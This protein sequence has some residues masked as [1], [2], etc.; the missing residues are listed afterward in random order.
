MQLAS[1]ARSKSKTY[2][3]ISPLMEDGTMVGI[4]LP[5]LPFDLDIACP[6]NTSWQASTVTEI[7]TSARSIITDVAEE[8]DEVYN[9]LTRRYWETLYL[10]ESLASVEHLCA[11]LLR[12]RRD[13]PA[14]TSNDLDSATD[15]AKQ[16]QEE[17]VSGT[18]RKRNQADRS[19]EEIP[20]PLLRLLLTIP[21]LE[22]KHRQGVAVVLSR[23]TSPY[24]GLAYPAKSNVPTEK[25]GD[26]MSTL[27][28]ADS[29]ANEYFSPLEMR[30]L[31]N[32]IKMRNASGRAEDDMFAL[33]RHLDAEVEQSYQESR[34]GMPQQGLQPGS[35][36]GKALEQGHSA[37]TAETASSEVSAK[38]LDIRTRKEEL[39]ASVMAASIKALREQ[40]ERREVLL[41]VILLL[42]INHLYET[43]TPL[44]REGE[45]AVGDE[46]AVQ[47]EDIESEYRIRK[48][49]KK[50]KK[51][52][53]S[54]VSTIHELAASAPRAVRRKRRR[55]ISAGVDNEDQETPNPAVM[56][57]LFADRLAL[58]QA[59]GVGNLGDVGP[60]PDHGAMEAG[61]SLDFD[62]ASDTDEQYVSGGPTRAGSRVKRATLPSARSMEEWDWIQRFCVCIV[63][64]YFLEI[65]HKFCE[66]FH[67]KVFGEALASTESGGEQEQP[68]DNYDTMSVHT[69]NTDTSAGGRERS[70]SRA[71]SVTS[72][73][74]RANSRL[75]SSNSLEPS[76]ALHGDQHEHSS[77][78][79]HFSR[80]PSVNS[81]NS[82][83]PL[84][85]TKSTANSSQLF[86]NRQVG[87]TRTNSSYLSATAN[88]SVNIVMG[89]R[90]TMV[91]P[92]PAN[93]VPRVERKVS[94][95][96]TTARK[97]ATMVNRRS[98]SGGDD[99]RYQSES[100]PTA[101]ATLALATPSKPR[102]NQFLARGSTAQT[103][104][105]D[106][107][108]QE[109]SMNIQAFDGSN[110]RNYG[111]SIGDHSAGFVAETPAL[112]NGRRMTADEQVLGRY[113]SFS[114]TSKVLS[115]PQRA[116]ES[117]LSIKA[118]FGMQ[119]VETDDLADFMVDTD[120]EEEAPLGKEMVGNRLLNNAVLRHKDIQLDQDVQEVPETPLK[121]R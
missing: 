35:E 22:R 94:G 55:S 103:Y 61:D 79:N 96:T 16:L 101:S 65:D 2:P 72:V 26:N 106:P 15:N 52:R 121:T 58:W 24:Y 14:R 92:M 18:K 57:D 81:I 46:D 98:A 69:V 20:S 91:V 29:K 6:I 87:F 102:G 85:R 78:E 119:N 8:E 105:R 28:S 115:F 120:D 63:E 10:P 100:Q 60:K 107:S 54:S 118:P 32:A 62:I 45:D 21:Q 111:S 31:E 117:V 50:K 53:I 67:L 5:D 38:L 7:S 51:K 112:P 33:H 84:P 90:K 88:G 48:S 19:T 97:P 99:S 108:R 64:R 23:V 86:K 3:F 36:D 104:V 68:V 49:K 70:F 34:S 74:S 1:N 47:F 83:D 40:L 82:R 42:V 95:D 25:N 27:P 114:T 37:Q 73:T 93:K 56:L 39:L 76:S 109:P 113:T 77:V 75:E 17:A 80:R 9:Y 59:I 116:S 11:D 110:L 44:A 30:I 12:I 89:K 43:A 41:Q 4:F 13:P 66:S 71:A